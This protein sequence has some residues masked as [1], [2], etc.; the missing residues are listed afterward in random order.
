VKV[1]PFSPAFSLLPFPLPV[2]M[3]VVAREAS[4][5]QT[6]PCLGAGRDHQDVC[7]EM[8]LERQWADRQ[9]STVCTGW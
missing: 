4:G 3:S 1:T 6:A 8:G 7:S 9:R 2:P 5:C